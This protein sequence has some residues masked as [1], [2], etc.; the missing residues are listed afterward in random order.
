[1]LFQ[2]LNNVTMTLAAPLDFH[3]EQLVVLDV[4]L[5]DAEKYDPTKQLSLTLVGDEEY[6]QYEIVYAIARTGTTFDIIRGQEDTVASGWPAGTRV[7]AA[8]SAGMLEGITETPTDADQIGYE[9]GNFGAA[10]SVEETLDDMGD[11]IIR[12][13]AETIYFEDVFQRLGASRFSGGSTVTDDL[14]WQDKAKHYQTA[15][16]GV[17]VTG[18][19]PI[20]QTP[21]LPDV[22]LCVRSTTFAK[23]GTFKVRA[24]DAAFPADYLEWSIPKTVFQPNNAWT[25]VYLSNRDAVKTGA[26]QTH[27][28]KS[29]SITV[30]D[31]STGVFACDINFVD[32][33]EE[34]TSYIGT[35][36]NVKTEADWAKV[37][38]VQK[39]GY[40]VSVVVNVQDLRNGVV[41]G[42]SINLVEKDGNRIYLSSVANFKAQTPD[43]ITVL[44]YE[45]V[46]LGSEI[47]I[48]PAGFVY[49]GHYNGPLDLDAHTS[50]RE[51]VLKAYPRGVGPGSFRSGIEVYR[52]DDPLYTVVTIAEARSVL[53]G[54]DNRSINIDVGT[55]SAADI[56]TLYSE[57]AAKGFWY[58]TRSPWE[59]AD[60]LKSG[61]VPI[62]RLPIVPIT[63]G[64]T[65]GDDVVE[66]RNNLGVEWD[67][68][69][70]TPNGP[71]LPPVGTLMPFLGL[72]IPAGWAY[73]N[74][75]AIA[76]ATYP[77]L[78]A[79][80]GTRFN[81]GGEASTHFRVPDIRGRLLAGVDDGSGR[82]TGYNSPGTAGGLQSVTLTEGQLPVHDHSAG[83][84]VA[85]SA[86]A[87]THTVSVGFY[88]GAAGSAERYSQGSNE[89]LP[90]SSNGAHTHTIS[91][92]TGNAGSGQAHMNVQPTMAIY[93][94]VRA[95]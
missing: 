39:Y 40:Q 12:E 91:G 92:N 65:G 70:V 20:T 46:R 27:L 48:K 93:W 10:G 5:P 81:T 9:G 54:T 21:F 75:Q 45:G 50:V 30:T 41:L 33:V 29:I 1:M 87:H 7:L 2:F 69:V 67:V 58:P 34:R 3:D 76:K 26:P 15:G 95:V 55:L 32:T 52:F 72:S 51:L 13:A 14:R 83:T 71:W 61:T 82:L 63:K 60:N 6:D 17:A 42:S 74:G 28:P 37:W 25:H 57:V 47:G 84:L 56:D 85:N 80:L 8:F 94:M 24:F 31:D 4:D 19:A 22:C 68:D 79:V 43:Q 89:S 49:P 77:K 59:N 86:G 35:F 36:I 88:S 18:S 44:L 66:A 78:Y 90:T 64:G 38:A 23:L 16:A 53:T 11:A 62:A 73:C